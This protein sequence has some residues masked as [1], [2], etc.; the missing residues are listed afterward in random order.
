MK[1]GKMG[2]LMWRVQ[3]LISCFLFLLPLL[4]QPASAEETGSVSGTTRV[5]VE[6][7]EIHTCHRYSTYAVPVTEESERTFQTFFGNGEKHFSG[8]GNF[9]HLMSTY[10]REDFD[11]GSK[12]EMPPRQILGE[13]VPGQKRSLCNRSGSFK[14]DDLSPGN[15][16][17]LAPVFWKHVHGVGYGHRL[18]VGGIFGQK[19]QVLAGETVELKFLIQPTGEPD[20]Q[21][22]SDT[23]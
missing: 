11:P 23:E 10:Y 22:G 4:M 1:L 14:I 3:I 15:W 12:L 16:Y 17:V 6:D 21:S 18:F 19:I 2:K 8:L 7:G 20:N 13:L 9:P 5:D